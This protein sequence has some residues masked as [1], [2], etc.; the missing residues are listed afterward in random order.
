M[1]FFRTQLWSAKYLIN[2]SIDLWLVKGRYNGMRRQNKFCDGVK[3]KFCQF[4]M[5]LASDIFT[6]KNPNEGGREFF[7]KK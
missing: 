1:F 4:L 3:F 7:F 6:G 2:I 5:V